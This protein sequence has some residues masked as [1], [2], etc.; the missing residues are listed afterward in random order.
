MRL[1]LPLLGSLICSAASFTIDPPVIYDCNGSVGK[2]ILRWN[3]VPGHIRIL[4]GPERALFAESSEATGSAETGTWVGDEL[5]FRL[6]SD[7]LDTELMARAQV[8]CNAQNVPANG[9][10]SESFYPLEVG[11]TWIYRVDSR[12]VTSGYL[13]WTVVSERTVGGYVYAELR[14]RNPDGIPANVPLLLRQAPD[15]A[16]WKFTGTADNPREELYVNPNAEEHHA[17]FNALGSYPD[18]VFQ[19]V[20]VPLQRET[21]VFVRGVG[22][23]RLRAD[24][25]TGSSGGLVQSLELVEYSLANGVRVTNPAAGISL[26]AE[27]AVFD[28]TGR[29]V[30]D[31]EVPCYNAACGLGGSQPQPGYRPCART[32][33]EVHGLGEFW[34]NLEM[35]DS[36]GRTVFRRTSLGPVTQPVAYL[37]VPLFSEPDK[38]LPPGL[39]TLVART[40][41]VEPVRA[42]ASMTIEIR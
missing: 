41:N 31:C 29:N 35:L 20:Q 3:G 22:L 30:T 4:V 26:S 10:T 12:S 24:L 6:V 38:P 8:R 21:R 18:A 27:R 2:A 28:V 36:A 25:L 14:N 16:I 33:V 11:N 15:G 23:V 19:T 34:T 40:D 9:I 32:R 39:Y 7:R 42:T 5:E 13:T 1:V 17:F 37:Q